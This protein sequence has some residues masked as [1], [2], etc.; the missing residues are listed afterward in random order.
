MNERSKLMKTHTFGLLAVRSFSATAIAI[1]LA[2]PALANA[3]ALLR[4]KEFAASTTMAKGEFVQKMQK[5]SAGGVETSSGVFAFA[6]PGKFRWD[7][8][9][10]F[11]QLMVAD[12]EKLFFYDKDLNQV[13]V[14]KLQDAVGASPAMLLF[15]GSDLDKYFNLKPLPGKDDVEWLEAL[16]KSKEA[17]F[18]RIILGFRNGLPA[19]MEVRD[20]FNRLTSFTFTGI[21]R[22]PKLDADIFRFVAPKGADVISQ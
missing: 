7:V 21:E 20:A 17:G 16:P 6:R 8:K 9:K 19:Q 12:G 22:N 4:L 10:P 1:A 11:E 13:T 5:S 14:K 2:W 18:D 15:G 3:D